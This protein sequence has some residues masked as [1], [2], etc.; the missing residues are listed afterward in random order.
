MSGP[1]LT[2][3]PWSLHR[4]QLKTLQFISNGVDKQGEWHELNDYILPDHVECL[5]VVQGPCDSCGQVLA[6][7]ANGDFCLMTL[8]APDIVRVLSAS[9]SALR[10]EPWAV[11]RISDADAAQPE[12]LLAYNRTTTFRS[13]AGEPMRSFQV[14]WATRPHAVAYVYPYMLAFTGSSL[15]ITTMINGNLI[16][17]VPLPPTHFLTSKEDVFFVTSNSDNQTYSVYRIGKVSGRCCRAEPGSLPCFVTV[18]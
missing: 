8:G 12:Y 7:L 17:S 5:S 2:L 1:I 4:R 6:G 15:E 14:N 9:T 3:R 13:A 10:A 18:L 11:M 16:K